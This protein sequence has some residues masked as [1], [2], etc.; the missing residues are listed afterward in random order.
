MGPVTRSR[1][2]S[3]GH[4]DSDPESDAPATVN[5]IEVHLNKAV[6]GARALQEELEELKRQNTKLK[7]RLEHVEQPEQPKR[8]RK[9]GPTF[10]TLQG[11][12]RE[13]KGRIR[14]LEKARRK[15]KK[16]IDKAR[17]DRLQFLLYLRIQEAK[18]DATELQDDAEL[19]VGDTAHTMRKQWDALLEIAKVWAKVDLLR[20]E[21][22][23]EEEAEEQFIDDEP[24]D[25]SVRSVLTGR[26]ATS[27]EPEV[28]HNGAD[29]KDDEPPTSSNPAKKR[30]I[31][32]SPESSPLSQPPSPNTEEVPQNE[33][34]M[35]QIPIETISNQ[36]AA[37]QVVA[38]NPAAVN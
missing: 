34:G 16:K 27:P 31:A 24:P 4:H 19:D 14:D 7:Q 22:T 3:V 26:S 17:R 28:Q 30:R 12:I 2:L 11:T 15:D 6:Q 37:E 8:G 1:R 32:F 5:E 35:S 21:D 20:Q 36:T 9:G 33:A 29:D 10:A 38:G 13:L 25:G 18:A 23:S